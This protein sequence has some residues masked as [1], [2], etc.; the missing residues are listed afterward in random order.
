MNFLFIDN[1]ENGAFLKARARRVADGTEK[2]LQLAWAL[3][4]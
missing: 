4:F 1:D 3:Q 2:W